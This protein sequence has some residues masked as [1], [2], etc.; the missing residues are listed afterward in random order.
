MKVLR[1]AKE[2][3]GI[4]LDGPYSYRDFEILQGNANCMDFFEDN[5]FD[6]VLCNAVL[7]HDKFFWKS[8]AEMRRV[9]K[10]GGLI[11]IGTPGYTR[12]P[13]GIL[14]RPL[15]V[16]H[17]IPLLRSI[18]AHEYLTWLFIGTLTVEVHNAP[19]DYYRF[20]TQSYREVFFAGMQDVEI[21]SVVVPPI[22]VGSGIKP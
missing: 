8:L 16:F 18:F 6:T 17:K 11:V 20:S 4:N 2:K 22:I 1:D 5:R 21:K 12:L 14:K 19:G 3:I 15:R 9:T 13:F 10:P 7:E